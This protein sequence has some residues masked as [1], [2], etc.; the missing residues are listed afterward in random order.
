MRRVFCIRTRGEAL[1]AAVLFLLA[2]AAP[3][4]AQTTASIRGTVKDTV[5]GAV[6]G[7]TVTATQTET[8]ERRTAVTGNGGGYLFANLPLGPYSVRAELEGFKTAVRDGI[9]LTLNR[10]ATVDL[11][12]E[13]GE[14]SEMVTV[15]GEAPLVEASTNEMG[16]LV[17]R[18]RVVELPLSG[19]NPLELIELVPGAQQVQSRPEQGFNINLVAINGARPEQSSWL[20][21]GGDNTSLLRNYGNNTPNPDAVQEFRVITNNFSAEYGRANGAVVNVVTRAGT[22]A[23]HGSGYEFF[24]DDALNG[25]NFFAGEPDEL[26]Q[27]QFG[28]TLGGPL[29]KDKTFFF[30]AYQGFRQSG[31][32]Y[33]NGAYLPT[34]LERRGDFSQSD[35]TIIDPLTGQPFPGNVIPAD[36]ITP[37]ATR[38]LDQVVPL[39]ND[40]ARGP[41]AYEE[42]IAYTNK[43]SE[44]VFRLD[45]S[46]SNRHKLSVSYFLND[47]VDPRPQAQGRA[48]F[49]HIFQDNTT[50]QH[51]VNIHEY[52]TIR[53]NLLNH[54]RL[55]Y[56]RAGGDRFLR[57][58][59]L[60]TVTDL[61]INWGNVTAGGEELGI[62]LRFD[63]YFR[64][65]APYGGAKTSNLYT[66]ADTVDWM[67]GRHHFKLGGEV[68]LRRLFDHSQSSQ[69]GGY[70][71]FN[72]RV[73]GD[74][75][76]DFLLGHVSHS[77]G[78]RNES[79]KSNNQW[80]FVAFAQDDFRVNNRLTLNLGLRYE[81][82]TW[83]VHPLDY[84]MTYREGQ[85]STCV[86]QAP[87]GFA[88]PCDPGI[89]RSGMNNDYNNFSPRLGFAYSLTDDSKTVVRGGY[90][91]FYGVTIF[92]ALQGGQ[93]GV[94]YTVSETVRNAA[95]SNEPSTIS[96]ENPWD[97]VP[98]GN[99][100]PFSSDP[101]NLAFPDSTDY[102]VANPDMKAGYLHQFNLSLQR[103]LGESTVVELA[104]IGSRGHNL[105]GQ[106]D[107]NSP[108]PSADANEG[109]IDERRPLIG[110]GIQALTMEHG[111]VR[112]WYDALQARVERRFS[113]GFSVL[114]S[115]TWGKAVDYETW[116]SSSGYWQDFRDPANNKGLSDNER[117]HMLSVSWLWELPICR[118]CNGFVGAL[119][120]GWSLNGIAA[121]YTGQPVDIR[122]DEDNNFD[123]VSDN[124]RPDLVGDWRQPKPSNDEI[125]NG[126]TWYNIDA[127]VPNQ[128]GQLGNMERNLI[129]GPG[130]K[131]VDLGLTK[132][133]R[134]KDGHTLQLRVEAFNVFDFVNLDLPVREMT[135][136]YF[137]QI[138]GS[139]LAR[140]I[141]LG[142][143]YRF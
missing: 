85:Q 121:F 132:N 58:E 115:Y 64:D 129:P 60:T 14:I 65:E 97:S 49:S 23:F 126:A 34:E 7:V 134:I 136:R 117:R 135:S 61:G 57:F 124:D 73:T 139:G 87:R 2:L 44:F 16:T 17:D 40:A 84:V 96:V 50:L 47:T 112:S 101:E 20:L 59:P 52:W 55:T 125:L 109:N 128:P 143:K 118:G 122:V 21:D 98:D 113:N 89:P 26:R 11:V 71:R 108:L 80:G 46:F 18:R 53:P 24:R 54:L 19:R 137:G 3:L 33:V 94:P 90:G 6:P 93:V 69:V 76:A 63:G 30:F 62:A 70:Y 111:F 88:F 35:V 103:Q 77:F 48:E 86:P 82:D 116:Y 127:L 10:T 66:L 130:F 51:N 133:F 43:R 102:N 41:H 142:V 22:N 15:Q 72:G 92:N 140:I 37:V 38:Y 13:V 67:K 131:N 141:Q 36:R 83:P 31:E 104:Y 99:P 119:L 29:V 68:N 100:F 28:V 78:Y 4:A 32:Q 91:L 39:P 9:E 107:F 81:V 1:A 120:D 12:L 75:M 123:G 79:Y 25:N 8:S 114:G 74:A 5:G 45:H 138:Q 56:N 106:L 110:D 95:G 42:T 27:H 105:L